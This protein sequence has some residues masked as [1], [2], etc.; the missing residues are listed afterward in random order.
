[1]YPVTFNMTQR[2]VFYL[3]LGYIYSETIR[4]LVKAFEKTQREHIIRED[5]DLLS[6][7]EE[8][9]TLEQR[10][11]AGKIMAKLRKLTPLSNSWKGH[12][13]LNLKT[14]LLFQTDFFV[15]IM[16]PRNG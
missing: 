12:M 9:L 4:S 3:A 15:P 16:V 1:M 6:K 10:Q 5:K 7:L 13:Q 11:Q 14:I 2:L 8:L